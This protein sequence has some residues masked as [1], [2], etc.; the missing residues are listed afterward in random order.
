[1][2]FYRRFPV[3]AARDLTGCQLAP[4]QRIVVRVLW[5]L[6]MWWG[7]NTVFNN[8][9][10]RLSKT[11]IF[12]L[13]A[14]L[15]CLLYPAQRF[16]PLGASGFRQGKRILLEAERVIANRIG[17]SQK[18]KNFLSR[19]LVARV[20]K[21]GQII[22]KESDAWSI[23]FKNGNEIRTIP[24]GN[25]PNKWRGEGATT[26]GIDEKKDLG[27]DIQ[28]KV[29]NPMGYVP[30]DPVSPSTPPSSQLINMGTIEYEDDIFT[31]E[32]EKAKQI[33]EQVARN[34]LSLSAL[35]AIVIQFNRLD[36][37]WGADEEGKRHNWT[38][39]YHMAH[40]KMLEDRD[41]GETDRDSWMAENMNIPIP[42]SGNF[43]PSTLVRAAEDHKVND[44]IDC[45]QESQNEYLI[46]L[47]EC[48]DPIVIGVD[49]ASGGPAFFTMV[50]IR[51]G[52]LSDKTWDSISQTGKADFNVVVNAFEGRCTAWEAA[53]KICEWLERY[54]HTLRV[55]MDK[56]GG[57]SQIADE[58][59][60]G[61]K[62][63]PA[64]YDPDDDDPET[65]RASKVEGGIPI[66]KLLAT[67]EVDN[68]EWAGFA[69]AQMETAK[70]FFPKGEIF[71][72][73]E[74]MNYAYSYLKRLKN[75]L[76]AVKTKPIGR[77]LKFYMPGDK[78]KDLFSSFIYAMGE[79][80]VKVLGEQKKRKVFSAFAWV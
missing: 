33:M 27:R 36:T 69:K 66:M 9:S 29:I 24:T 48:A 18:H 43:F 28:E 78:Q 23:A 74:A 35:W 7:V 13:I 56:R 20:G 68:T 21:V 59:A 39:P 3:F 58:L 45:N 51:V 8:M 76:T 30:P 38:I 41:T 62:D 31:I 1:M 72:D 63:H 67:T 11:F 54:P 65:G 75:Q 46:P 80:R 5:Y 44:I 19:S 40:K 70:L 77:G 61:L 37:F 10:R 16:M 4:H 73:T 55:A 49:A 17:E 12:A 50:A 22:Y 2:Y 14:S 47:L 53:A 15:K 64:L 60:F 32:I 6:T 52:M 57:G 42:V 79:V 71:G 25:D 26:I 34:D